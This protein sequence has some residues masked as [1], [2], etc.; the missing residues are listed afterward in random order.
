MSD[1]SVNQENKRKGNSKPI[2][3]RL[4]HND[5]LDSKIIAFFEGKNSS[6]WIRRAVR[7][8]YRRSVQGPKK[9]RLK[10]QQLQGME[11]K[12]EELPMQKEF[13]Q[14]VREE[15]VKRDEIK[16]HSFYHDFFANE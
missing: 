3:S 15:V 10:R 8:E 13:V 7:K 9:Y 14:P 11:E 1:V 12:F 2:A 4:L 6:E 5:D 16:E